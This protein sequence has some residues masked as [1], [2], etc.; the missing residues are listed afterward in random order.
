M[1]KDLDSV[2]DKTDH[3]RPEVY[4]PV[5]AAHPVFEDNI[6]FVAPTNS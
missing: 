4:F 5:V 1:L 2:Y 3:S 6:I